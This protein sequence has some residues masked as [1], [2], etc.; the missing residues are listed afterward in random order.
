[1][2]SKELNVESQGT[3]NPNG[4]FQDMKREQC[5]RV[6]QRK[7]QGKTLTSKAW[8]PV[9]RTFGPEKFHLDEA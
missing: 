3:E 8:T 1:M 2:V 9:T 7:S 4:K 6:C 5:P